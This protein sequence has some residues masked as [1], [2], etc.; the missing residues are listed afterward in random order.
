MAVTTSARPAPPASRPARPRRPRR[1][2]TNYLFLAPATIFVLTMTIYPLLYNVSMSLHDVDAGAL[3]RGDAE[4]IGLANYVAVLGRPEVWSSL[5]I[6]LTY[7]GISVTL[8]LILGFLLALL[9]RRRFPG[10]GVI[11]ALLLLAWILPS[12]V[13]GN[14]FRWMLDGDTG[15]VNYIIRS[16]GYPENVFWLTNEGTAT[17]GVVLA[18]V[19]SGAPLAMVLMLAGLLAIPD[20]IYESAAVAGANGWQVTRYITIPMIRPV[21]LTAAI[22]SLIYTFKTFD[23]IYIMTRGGPAG[24]TKVLPI[25]AYEQAFQFFRFGEGAVATT[26]LLVIPLAISVVYY[27]L[28]RKD[29]ETTS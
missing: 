4:F 20:S 24:S 2:N 25:F 19:W 26:L 21:I 14:I 8:I 12:V 7:T 15:I 10:A 27:F 11:R 5:G 23:T 16:L 18:T 6:S 22:L 28:T 1:F 29:Q 9:F 13:S 3:I 17:A